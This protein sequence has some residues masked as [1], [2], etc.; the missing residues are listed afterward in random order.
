VNDAQLEGP[1]RKKT[2]KTAV[3]VFLRQNFIAWIEGA[4]GSG[5]HMTWQPVSD[6]VKWHSTQSIVA[7]LVGKARWVAV[8]A[9]SE[10]ELGHTQ[11]KPK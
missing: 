11:G 7:N 8:A 3:A 10:I 6:E 9:G 4:P 2:S 1:N 5:K